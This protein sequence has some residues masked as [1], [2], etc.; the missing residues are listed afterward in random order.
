MYKNTIQ[1]VIETGQIPFSFFYRPEVTVCTKNLQATTVICAIQPL[2]MFSWN[3][4]GCSYFHPFHSTQPLHAD[5]FSDSLTLPSSLKYQGNFLSLIIHW[6][7]LTRNKTQSQ[8]AT[9]IEVAIVVR[10]P[11]YVDDHGTSAISPRGFIFFF[12]FVRFG[13]CYSYAESFI[14]TVSENCY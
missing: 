3:R 5:V 12:F 8:S 4:F 2:F 11:P 6:R 14:A 7:P 1:S 10:R 13:H 9:Q